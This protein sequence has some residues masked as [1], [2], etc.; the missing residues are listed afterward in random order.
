MPLRKRFQS[1]LPIMMSFRMTYLVLI[2][3]CSAAC[4][5]VKPYEKEFLLNKLMDDSYV[6]SLTPKLHQAALAKYEH[7]GAGK[8]SSQGAQACPTC[9]G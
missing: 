5:T 2:T 9:G 1:A 7:L 6:D 4:A 3:M 8:G